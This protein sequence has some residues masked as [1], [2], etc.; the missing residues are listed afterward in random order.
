LRF[1]QRER[2]HE[3]VLPTFR[4]KTIAD[5][6]VHIGLESKTE[7]RSIKNAF[8]MNVAFDKNIDVSVGQ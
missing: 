6:K 5:L 2:A 8:L 7:G 3:R 4:A 1:K